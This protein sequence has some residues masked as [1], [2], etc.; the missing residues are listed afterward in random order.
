MSITEILI[1][2][3][4]WYCLAMIIFSTYY[5]IRGVM[6]H[7]R[8]INKIINEWTKWE[9]IVILYIQEII[10][11]VIITV[12]S[13]SALYLANHILLNIKSINDVGIGLVGLLIFLLVW[14][15]IG[16]CGYLTLFISMGKIPGMNK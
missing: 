2:M 12:S 5:A 13:F 8:N 11:K 1:G 6:Y 16:V 3:P 9:R 14:G 10:F 15:I 7:K 4:W